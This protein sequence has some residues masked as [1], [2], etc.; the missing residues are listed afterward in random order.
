MSGD[1]AGIESLIRWQDPEE[2]LISPAVF[3]PI[4]E[5]SGLIS[6]ITKWVIHNV[7][8][9]AMAWYSSGRLTVPVSINISGIEFKRFDLLAVVSSCLEQT[10][11][12]HELLELELSETSLH[13]E[14]EHAIEIYNNLKKLG[15]GITLDNFGAG[16]SSVSYLHRLPVSTLKIDRSFVTAIKAKDDDCAV[17]DAVIAQG[18]ALGLSI[19]AV[20]VETEIQ[21]KQLKSKNCDVMQGFLLSQPLSVE[22]MTS[23]LDELQVA[24]L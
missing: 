10:E 15:V 14:S 24:D 2:G 6:E 19:V 3:I 22:D 12:P 7:C 18:H 17:I 5:D 8:T 13:S 4:A 21:R 23:K 16:F 1:L 11:L 9:Q 20:G